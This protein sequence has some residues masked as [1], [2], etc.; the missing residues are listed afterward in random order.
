MRTLYDF[1]GAL[2][3]DNAENLRAAFR[4]AAKG[5]HPDHNPGDPDAALRF[6]Q[7]VRANEILSDDVQRAAYDQLLV[8]AR[9]EQQAAPK[10]SAADAI[11]RITNGIACCV[12]LLAGALIV[13]VGGYVL[14]GLSGATPRASA[15]VTQVFADEPPQDTAVTTGLSPT[16]GRSGRHNELGA[17]VT[18][19]KIDGNA[20]DFKPATVPGAAAPSHDTAS[21]TAKVPLV[22]DF[23]VNDAKHYRERGI[24]AYRTGDLHLALVDFDLAIQFDPNSPDVYIDRA[25]VFYRL[26]DRKRAFADVA[27]AKRIHQELTRDKTLPAA[28]AF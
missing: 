5:A 28:I 17:V 13:F 15:Q 7:L 3:D 11:C 10:R 1:L 6:R 27:Q 25:V 16:H 14:S 23:G 20:E 2:P 18:A 26:G 8:L 24:F 4:R 21:A 9:R 12:I 22:R 19:E